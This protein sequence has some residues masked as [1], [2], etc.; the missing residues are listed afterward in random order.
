MN[1]G[2]NYYL[3]PNS[4]LAKK[5]DYLF[6]NNVMA[7]VIIPTIFSMDDAMSAC[8]RGPRREWTNHEYSMH[9]R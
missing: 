8:L 5:F 6:L 9:V 2:F 4:V 3:F 7:G 1:L